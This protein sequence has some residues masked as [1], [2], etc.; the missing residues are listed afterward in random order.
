MVR[1]KK[2][3]GQNFLQDQNVL[4]KII[5]AIPKETQPNSNGRVVEIGPG[6]GDLTHWLLKSGYNTISYEID[7]ELISNLENKFKNEAK[8]GHF[9][10]IN[11]DANLVWH[12]QGSLRGEP[13]ILVANL[14]YYV[15]T[16]MIL[17]ALQDGFCA[18]VVAMIQREV[19]IK[20]SSS[21]GSSEFSSLGVLANLNGSCELLFDV[22]PECFSPT[23]KVVSSVLRIV[24]SKRLIGEYGVFPTLSEYDKFKNY[25]KICFSAPRKTLF[26]NLTTGYDKDMVAGI[27]N[28]LNLVQ[29]IRPHESNVA[30][31][32]KI[33][34]Q[35]KA[36]NE[37][38]KSDN[39]TEQE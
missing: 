36:K 7:S 8:K 1:A 29:N 13:Y 16:K 15:A 4:N 6:L 3:F 28:E 22:P 12:K 21:G 11:E 2:H 32:L 37:R 38:R 19:A 14:P 34:N 10:L 39:Q 35:I 33:Y 5:Q 31:Y 27:F 20:F 26:K 17:N 25:L 23:P 24:K 9:K 18:G 30:L